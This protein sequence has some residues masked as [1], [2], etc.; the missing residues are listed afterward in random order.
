MG[1]FEA[2]F[3][4]IAFQRQFCLCCCQ[5]FR[6]ITCLRLLFLLFINNLGSPASHSNPKSVIMWGWTQCYNFF[7]KPELRLRQACFLQLSCVS[8]W[9]FPPPLSTCWE[10]SSSEFSVF[11]GEPFPKCFTGS[12]DHVLVWFKTPSWYRSANIP[13]PDIVSTHMLADWIFNLLY[14]GLWGFLLFS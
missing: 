13:R 14:F 7:F 11:L 5:L 6:D 4:Q 12:Q 9:I 1:L 3:F 10:H 8:E 2:V